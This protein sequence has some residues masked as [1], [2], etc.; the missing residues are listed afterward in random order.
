M[1][2]D[3]V[4]SNPRTATRLGPRNYFPY[5]SSILRDGRKREEEKNILP[6]SDGNVSVMREPGKCVGWATICERNWHFA[7]IESISP[8][9]HKCKKCFLPNLWDR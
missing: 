2:S 1:Q 4:S 8:L 9:R 3:R 7:G 6:F 5:G